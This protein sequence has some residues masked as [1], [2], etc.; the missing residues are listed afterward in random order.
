MLSYVFHSSYERPK[1]TRQKTTINIR[2]RVR[3]KQFNGVVLNSVYLFMHFN[4]KKDSVFLL[5]KLYFHNILWANEH[6]PRTHSICNVRTSYIQLTLIVYDCLLL[7]FVLFVFSSYEP[8]LIEFQ[9]TVSIHLKYHFSYSKSFVPFKTSKSVSMC[10][11]YS[12]LVHSNTC[13]N[14]LQLENLLPFDT[15]YGANP[16]E[17]MSN[18]NISEMFVSLKQSLEHI[19]KHHLNLFRLNSICVD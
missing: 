17:W 6:M 19:T 1:W 9:W 12:S 5:H 14:M 15:T 2:M 3:W 8:L 13:V 16:T 7:I 10:F 18:R 4:L 11:L